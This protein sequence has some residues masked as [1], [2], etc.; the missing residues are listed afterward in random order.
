M[1]NEEKEAGIR[2]HL[3]QEEMRR[4]M[5]SHR[6]RISYH[7]ES[8]RESLSFH[9]LRNLHYESHLLNQSA[10]ETFRDARS[11]YR[12]VCRLI[13]NAGKEL[14]RLK[15]EIKA[16]EKNRNIREANRLGD[17]HRVIYNALKGLK[18]EKKKLYQQKEEFYLEMA[19]LM[20]RTRE[21]KLKIR[22]NCGHGGRV[23]YNSIEEKTRR[24][25]LLYS[26]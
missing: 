6:S 5:Y 10:R 9:Q 24:K 26:G 1:K 23:W 11:S 7:I 25:A 19:S 21:L 12:A 18:K 14:D 8:S 2:F 20:E 22:N 15:V 13:E 16:A 17:K 3:K 4:E